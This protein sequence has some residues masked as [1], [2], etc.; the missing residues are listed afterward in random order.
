MPNSDRALNSDVCLITRFYNMYRACKGQGVLMEAEKANF[1]LVRTVQRA[2]SA[3]CGASWLLHYSETNFRTL[4]RAPLCCVG[5]PSAEYPLCTVWSHPPRCVE[6][7]ST[8]RRAR[9]PHCE[10]Q[11][12]ALLSTVARNLLT[13]IK[14][15]LY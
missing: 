13:A 8:L 7:P 10:E 5:P 4:R 6:H 2:P 12:T 1:P 11:T 9:S 3:Q 15:P 14:D